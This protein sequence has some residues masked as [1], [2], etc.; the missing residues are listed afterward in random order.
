MDTAADLA[1]FYADFGTP[2]AHT[3]AGGVASDP[4]IVLIDRNSGAQLGGD[5]IMGV[6]TVQYPL[7]SFTPPPVRGDTFTVGAETWRITEAPQ[8]T[9]DGL[10]AIAPVTRIA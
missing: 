1:L 9:N 10:E 4:Q 2:A 7:T 3:P 8:V 5:I 6:P